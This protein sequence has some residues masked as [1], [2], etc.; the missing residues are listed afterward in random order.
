MAL[1]GFGAV[2][3][4]EMSRIGAGS[5]G[6]FVA[7]ATGIPGTFGA[8]NW[9]IPLAIRARNSVSNNYSNNTSTHDVIFEFEGRGQ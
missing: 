4:R 3:Y 9:L 6:T 8:A 1:P 7:A 2:D 5:W